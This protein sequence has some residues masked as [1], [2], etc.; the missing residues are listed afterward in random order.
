MAGIIRMTRKQLGVPMSALAER[1]GIGVQAVS[2]LEL[3]D[4]RGAIRVET[5]ERALRALGKRDIVVVVDASDDG[6]DRLVE[7]QADAQAAVDRAVWSLGLDGRQVTDEAV[8]RLVQRTVRK[9]I[10]AV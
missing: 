4:E 7:L 10:S 8:Q 1:L 9:K 5:R 6:D 2:T 3:N